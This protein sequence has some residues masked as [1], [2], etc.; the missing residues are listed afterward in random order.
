MPH[1]RQGKKS[2]SCV[3]RPVDVSQIP[4]PFGC[5][6]VKLV[7]KTDRYTEWNRGWQDP[8][9]QHPAPA[10]GSP[11]EP[12]G[13]TATC[14]PLLSLDFLPQTSFPFTLLFILKASGVSSVK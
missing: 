5:K 10:L 11:M 6:E 12:K 13:T 9:A 2:P 3:C 14:P 7:G 4:T 1:G 8:H